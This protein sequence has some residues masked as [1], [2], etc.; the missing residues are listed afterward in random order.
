M[1]FNVLTVCIGNI[2]R[3]TFAAAM[4]RTWANWYLPA[5]LAGRV[6]IS[7]AGLGAAVGAPMGQRVRTIAAQLG[8]EDLDHRA[9]ALTDSMIQSA[10]LVLTATR[11]QRD[12]V[13]ERMPSALPLTFTIREAGRIA[14]TVPRRGPRS[15][16]QPRN[17][18][19]LDALVAE[20]RDRRATTAAGDDDIV[21]PHGFDDVVHVRMVQQELPALVHLGH[22]ML[23]MPA[24]DAR[25]YLAAASDAPALM[26]MLEER[27]R[28]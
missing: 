20:L 28:R 6:R 10:R 9:V 18:L 5:D 22:A 8:A 26:R 23:G 14:E 7:S 13:L 15:G 19:Q 24:A 27:A 25:A 2:H 4:L 17:V 3:S 12:D 11:Q 1:D 16:L 21:D